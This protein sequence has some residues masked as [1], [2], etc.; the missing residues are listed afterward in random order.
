MANTINPPKRPNHLRAGFATGAYGWLAPKSGGG[1]MSDVG[2][3]S[4]GG[5]G[6]S[7]TIEA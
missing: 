4:L 7:V 1:A 5:A 2:L 6:W 3:I